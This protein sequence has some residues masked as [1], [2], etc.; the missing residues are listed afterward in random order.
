MD[1][2]HAYKQQSPSAF[3]KDSSGCWMEQMGKDKGWGSK[4]SCVRTVAQVSGGDRENGPRLRDVQKRALVTLG[5]LCRELVQGCSLECSTL[6]MACCWF[7][8]SCSAPSKS[9]EGCSALRT[10]GTPE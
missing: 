8:N 2:V 3:C 10:G 1:S 4:T 5:V 6:H 7:T 9:S